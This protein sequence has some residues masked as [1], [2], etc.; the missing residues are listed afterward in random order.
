MLI[1][2][3]QNTYETKFLVSGC[4]SKILSQ[5]RDKPIRPCPMMATKTPF[6]MKSIQARSDVSRATFPS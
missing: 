5:S 1:A 4:F 3:S 6:L 2:P